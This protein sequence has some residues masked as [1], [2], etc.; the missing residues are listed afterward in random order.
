VFDTENFGWVAKLS[1]AALV[2]EHRR[3]QQSKFMICAATSAP[4]APFLK[5]EQARDSTLALTPAPLCGS[6]RRL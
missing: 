4:R 6:K 3:E 1:R 2:Q 5:L